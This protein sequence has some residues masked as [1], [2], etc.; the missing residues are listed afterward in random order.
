MRLSWR[1]RFVAHA[2]TCLFVAHIE[3]YTGA[4]CKLWLARRYRD[5]SNAHITA[6]ID[7]REF[8]KAMGIGMVGCF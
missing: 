1:V 3:V 6:K 7:Y 8:T 4:I 2:T 5:L